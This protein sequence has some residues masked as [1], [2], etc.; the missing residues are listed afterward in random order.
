MIED[1]R[2]CHTPKSR[3]ARTNLVIITAFHVNNFM[4]FAGSSAGSWRYETSFVA[5]IM[6]IQVS[7]VNRQNMGNSVRALVPI[8]RIVPNILRM[9]ILDMHS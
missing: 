7:L 5:R 1:L 9:I 3:Y 2:H 4:L 6:L 8:Y